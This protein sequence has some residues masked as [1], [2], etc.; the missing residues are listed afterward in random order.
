VGFGIGRP[1][2]SPMGVRKL[3]EREVLPRRTFP[4][5]VGRAGRRRHRS[6]RSASGEAR[7]VHEAPDP[8][9]LH[10]IPTVLHLR[11]GES[12]SIFL[13]ASGR[14]AE[15]SPAPLDADLRRMNFA[16][17]NSWG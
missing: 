14:R 16:P 10:P 8:D 7:G 11:H 3:K 5:A 12:P 4:L 15:N 9:E 2:V 6:L 1:A 17:T 13:C